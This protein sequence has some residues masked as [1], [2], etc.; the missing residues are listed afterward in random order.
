MI[1]SFVD[2]LGCLSVLAV[3]SP[4]KLASR[5]PLDNCKNKETHDYNI[6]NYL[7]N[8]WLL[9]GITV[10]SQTGQCCSSYASHTGQTFV[11]VVACFNRKQKRLMSV[12]Q[13]PYEY[14]MH[15]IQAI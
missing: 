1:E 7:Q 11:R 14:E 4:N 2:T 3:L 15:G 8:I 6:F 13:K 10:Q 9:H 5:P 12:D